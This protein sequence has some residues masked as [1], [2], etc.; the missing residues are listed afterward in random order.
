MFSTSLPHHFGKNGFYNTTCNW[1]GHSFN[2]D[3]PQV[4]MSLGATQAD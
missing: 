2:L 4:Q 1:Q 3:L